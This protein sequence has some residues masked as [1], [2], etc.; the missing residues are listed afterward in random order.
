MTKI[1]FFNDIQNSFRKI[2]KRKIFTDFEKR[3]VDT[4]S[5]CIRLSVGT[6]IMPIL[7]AKNRALG[8]QKDID[9]KMVDSDNYYYIH[10]VI[11]YHFA[12]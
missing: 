8:A 12:L 2:R 1:E 6:P 9:S 7:S 5:S 10:P 4:G 3:Q 11:I